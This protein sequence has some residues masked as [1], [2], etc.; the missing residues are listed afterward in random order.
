MQKT[1]IVLF[2]AS[3]LGLLV[4]PFGVFGTIFIFDDV[5]A[6]GLKKIVDWSVAWSVWLY[7]MVWGISLATAIPGMKRTQASRGTLAPALVPFYLPCVLGTIAVM[8]H[9]HVRGW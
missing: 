5:P 4:W 8:E 7:P 9:F 2:V 6:G 1:V 3:G